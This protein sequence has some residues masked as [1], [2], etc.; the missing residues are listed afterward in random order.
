MGPDAVRDTL[1]AIIQKVTAQ[2]HRPAW[3]CDAMHPGVP[4]GTGGGRP[5]PRTFD[6]VLAEVTGFFAVHRELGTHAGG[7]HVELTGREIGGP[8]DRGLQRHPAPDRVMSLPP[9]PCLTRAGALDLAFL[10][11]QAYRGAL[12]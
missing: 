3:I 10:V 4:V 8:E 6:D 9:S 7:L 1:P 11:A 5:A 2:G 12:A